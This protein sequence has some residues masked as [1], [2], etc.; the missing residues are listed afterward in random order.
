M[1]LKDLSVIIHGW[2]YY[3]ICTEVSIAYMVNKLFVARISDK[4]LI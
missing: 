4:I 1:S 3:N 2:N